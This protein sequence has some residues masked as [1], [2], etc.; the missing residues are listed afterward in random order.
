MNVHKRLVSKS[1]PIEPEEGEFLYTLSGTY[2]V[3][4]EFDITAF[5]PLMDKPSPII[6]RTTLCL[7]IRL[8]K[9]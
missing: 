5:S 4:K 6:W 1:S 9:G 8:E 2:L 7:L 3:L